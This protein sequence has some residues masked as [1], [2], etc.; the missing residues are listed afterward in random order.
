MTRQARYNVFPLINRLYEYRSMILA[1]NKDFTDSDE[2]FR[3]DNVAVP[4]LIE[5]FNTH[6]S[7]CWVAID[8][9]QPPFGEMRNRYAHLWF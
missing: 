9:S 2:L 6:T 7:L 3:N 8:N 1:T 5:S 4:K